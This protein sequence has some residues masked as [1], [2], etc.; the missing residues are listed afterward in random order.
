MDVLLVAALQDLI[1]ALI[2]RGS[3][4][5]WKLFL[6]M[7]LALAAA[8]HAI[9]AETLIG[10]VTAERGSDGLII[11]GSI[12]SVPPGTK[13]RV[14]IV[15]VPGR[16]LRSMER[17]RGAAIVGQDGL[18]QATLPSQDVALSEAGTYT[19][20]LT[21]MFNR[22]WQSAQVLQ[23]VGVALDSQDRSTISTNPK[24]DEPEPNR[25]M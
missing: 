24:P 18:F 13:L 10:K 9:A 5:P 16:S 6:T 25:V 3:R 4:G 14:D 19:I 21:A 12:S 22:G 17:P 11:A 8:E 23:K 15:R 7:A 1:P 2:A 20:Q